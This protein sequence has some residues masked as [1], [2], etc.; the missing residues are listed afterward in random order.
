M[1]K[2]WKSGNDNGRNHGPDEIGAE[3]YFTI[4]YL[5]RFV[6]AQLISSYVVS[7]EKHFIVMSHYYHV[8]IT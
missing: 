6:E 4:G 5:P 2:T 3:S 7:H 8:T 1:V